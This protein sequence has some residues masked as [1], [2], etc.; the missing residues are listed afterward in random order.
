MDAE[1]TTSATT[2]TS[3]AINKALE[4]IDNN[5]IHNQTTELR[6]HNIEKQLTEQKQTS[7][8]ILN[9]LKRQCNTQKKTY[10]LNIPHI[11]P[12]N[13]NKKRNYPTNTFNTNNDIYKQISPDKKR[14]GILG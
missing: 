7:N 8:E 5:N 1:R 13:H 6:I 11:N 2:P 3:K 14:K 12:F 4:K 10:T 9:H